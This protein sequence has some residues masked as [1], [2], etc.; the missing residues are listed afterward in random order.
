MQQCDFCSIDAIASRDFSRAR[1]VARGL[2]IAKS[3]GSYEE[4]IT[5]PDIDAIYNPLPNHLHVEWTS[6][7]AEAGK[8][9]LCE[10]P[11]DLTSE[12]AER[13]IELRDR[14]GVYIQEAFMVRTHP[15]WLKSREIIDSGKIGDLR[16]I[17]GFC[18][19]YNVDPANIR[20]KSDIGGGGLLDIGCYP[21][22]TSRFVTGTEPN[23]IAAAI[24]HDPQMSIDRL[25]SVLMMFP[26]IQA[27]FTYGTQLHPF[28]T[29]RFHG[30]AGQL[31]VEIP[32]NAPSDQPCKLM[33]ELREP[34]GSEEFIIAQCD[35]YG[36]AADAF[37]RAVL[38]QAEQ[39]VPLE[40]TLA[41][42]RAIDAV[43]RAADEGKWVAIN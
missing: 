28:Q 38:S 29:M 14:T 39:P 25:G 42:M 5:D 7:A 16:A 22:T 19:Y 32:F 10:K 20:N 30:T 31:T 18:S 4:L 27:T 8:H 17:A 34:Q 33:L 24:D 3:Y 37:A 1:N 13:L 43:F 26:G 40:D 2:G 35:Q 15:Q 41:N 21:I 11:I 6:K 9:V 36:V 23:R 12:G